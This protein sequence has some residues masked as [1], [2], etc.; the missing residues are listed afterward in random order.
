M[1]NS[2]IV[3]KD[4]KKGLLIK[5]NDNIGYQA[6]KQE[7]EHKINSAKTFFSSGGRIELLHSILSMEE[8]QELQKYLKHQ[9]DI[10]VVW[11]NKDTQ[12]KSKILELPDRQSVDIT[13]E[14]LT[15]FVDTTVRSGQRVFYQGNIVIMGDVNP[16]GEV[17]AGGNI[18]VMGSIRGIAHA[19]CFGNL[20]STISA[21]KLMPTQLRIGEI[22]SR[23]PDSQKI[24]RGNLS[25]ELACV[26]DNMIIIELIS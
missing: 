15:K 5:I 24:K 17:I 8:R 10:E 1:N 22:I 3:F 23:S 14:G 25:P 6:V 7:I 18:V 19:G 12:E 2:N 16:G 11:R 20:Q 13:K 4:N 9:Y 26:K 21:F